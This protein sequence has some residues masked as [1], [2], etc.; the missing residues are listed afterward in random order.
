M[1]EQVEG[2]GKSV[3]VALI[4]A[5]GL[6]L[7]V[8]G[9]NTLR[10]AP[11]LINWVQFQHLRQ[12]GLLVRIVARPSGW[13]CHL[14]ETVRLREG[15]EQREVSAQVVVLPDVGPIDQS[16]AQIWQDQG[17]LLASDVDP[18]QES[19]WPGGVFMGGL[20]LLGGW[21]LWS[22]IYQDLRGKGSPRRRLQE[23]EEAF[24]RGEMSEEEYQDARNALW[25]EM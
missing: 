16:Q 9:L 5:G 13:T 24:K 22:Q 4:L 12:E 8:I 20:L 7:L 6:L 3:R 14:S 25:A 2:P 21:Y 19:D 10:S 1:A 18:P 15:R 23:L 17:I 11:T